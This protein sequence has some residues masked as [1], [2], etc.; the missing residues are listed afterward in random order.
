MAARPIAIIAGLTQLAYWNQIVGCRGQISRAIIEDLG[1]VEHLTEGEMPRE[2]YVDRLTNN[3][4][5][6]PTPGYKEKN[7]GCY[8][9]G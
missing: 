6:S 2:S 8:D 1:I 4:R 7:Y 3:S 9:Y 5:T